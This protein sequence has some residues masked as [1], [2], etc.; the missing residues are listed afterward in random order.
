MRMPGCCSAHLHVDINGVTGTEARRPLASGRALKL[1]FIQSSLRFAVHC[2]IWGESFPI[3]VNE[4]M[5]DAQSLNCLS[6]REESCVVTSDK[7]MTL[8]KC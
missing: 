8:Y 2:I 6:A 4:D 7:D 5:P 1:R 3:Q